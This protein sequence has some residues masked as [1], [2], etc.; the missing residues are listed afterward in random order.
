MEYSGGPSL[1]G[2]TPGPI[3]T[4][5]AVTMASDA[6]LVRVGVRVRVRVRVGVGV[7]VGVRRK[8]RVRRG[9]ESGLANPLPTRSP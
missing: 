8:R 5:P 1:T 2:P 3:T 6:N 9:S 4:G 7:R